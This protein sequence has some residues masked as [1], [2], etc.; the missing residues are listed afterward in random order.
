MVSDHAI[1]NAPLAVTDSAGKWQRKAEAEGLR[2]PLCCDPL[3]RLAQAGII[4][5]DSR[6]FA[7]ERIL[8]EVRLNACSVSS[9]PENYQV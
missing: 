6:A 2:T 9:T 1:R 5:H 4:R 8:V 3:R 7:A